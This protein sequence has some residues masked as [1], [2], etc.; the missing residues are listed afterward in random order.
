MAAILNVDEV[1]EMAVRTEENGAAFYR[2]AAELHPD[3]GEADFL[4]A[5][6]ET[7]DDHARTFTDMRAELTDNE[8]CGAAYDPEGEAAQYIDAMAD[9]SGAEGSPQI[10]DSLTGQESVQDILETA[11]DLEKNSVLF[12]LGLLDLVGEGTAIE[13][14]GHIIR[15]EKNHVAVLARELKKMKA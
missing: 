11:I 13:K 10:A 9:D 4:L 15:E 8:K 14:I 2:R 5:L 3:S 7:E 6:A 1:F 12:Y